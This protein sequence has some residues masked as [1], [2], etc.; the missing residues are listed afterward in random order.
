LHTQSEHRSHGKSAYL[1]THVPPGIHAA[2]KG[3]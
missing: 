3:R 2:E 1:K